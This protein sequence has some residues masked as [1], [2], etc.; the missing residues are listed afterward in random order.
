MA[1]VI[2]Q[3]TAPILALLQGVWETR[4]PFAK[5][6]AEAARVRTR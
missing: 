5:A 6:V 4:R 2:F 3:G 1:K